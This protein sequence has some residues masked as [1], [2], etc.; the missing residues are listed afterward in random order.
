MANF[1]GIIPVTN[2]KSV[3]EPTCSGPTNQLIMVSLAW[4]DWE[5]Y[6]SLLDRILVHPK[7]NPQHFIRLPW[8]VACTH[9]YYWL[10]QERYCESIA[11][12]LR[13]QYINLAWLGNTSIYIIVIF[14]GFPSSWDSLQL[15]SKQHFK[16]QSELTATLTPSH[17]S[18]GSKMQD[19][20]SSL[21][22]QPPNC[23]QSF[24]HFQSWN[25]AD[26]G[27]RINNY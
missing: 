16:F 14:R 7:V 4:R 21:V 2:A 18:L 11:F 25:K 1:V 3:L 10:E 5:Y 22:E 13:A 6:N 27:D 9:L 17:M 15:S 24:Q 12:C 23:A 8:Q 19:Q 26:S 20:C